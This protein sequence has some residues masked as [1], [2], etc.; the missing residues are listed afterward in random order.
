LKF[1]ILGVDKNY[2]LAFFEEFQKKYNCISF[3]YSWN[4]INESS[5]LS[6]LPR[7]D[8][9]KLYKTETISEAFQLKKISVLDTDFLK[10][11][12]E[13]K[14]VFLNTIDRCAAAPISISKIN[15]LY[16][17]LLQFY[18]SFFEENQMLTHVF[19]P[20]TPHFAPD[21]ILFYVSKYFNKKTIILTRTD[22]DNKY[23]L[24][25]DWRLPV[26]Y[27]DISNKNY[28]NNYNKNASSIFIEHS[29]K[30]NEQS[31]L[32]NL[33]KVNFLDKLKKYYFIFNHTRY[34]YINQSLFSSIYL[35]NDIKFIDLLRIIYNRIKLNK[36]L[37][38]LYISISEN[39]I[40]S[41]KYIY[42]PLHFQP[43]RSTQPEG[44][45]F[46]NQLLA[47]RLLHTNL[48][49]DYMIY[50]KEHPRQFD[51]S[52][53]DL[54]KVHSRI[55]DFYTKI[56][57]L[58]RVKLINIDYNSTELI[59]NASIVATITGSS[60]WQALKT[61]KPIFIFGYPWYSSCFGAFVIKNSN[62][63]V[64]SFKEIKKLNNYIISNEVENFI[65]RIYPYLIDGYTGIKGVNGE[66]PNL[67]LLA[68]SFSKKL[69]SYAIQIK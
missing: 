7:I 44:S 31:L 23:I 57:K 47:I 64:N 19:F 13:C 51:N 37:F 38:N 39:P 9:S 18:K 25:I 29:K 63:I 1:L 41:I 60:G 48:P 11:M 12:L 46:E 50:V 17:E 59:N 24:N 30:L 45:F 22:F 32:Y 55:P 61:G 3:I 5:S 67:D 10:E 62:D 14:T 15:T 21:I 68:E 20:A 36:T 42:F 28:L 27:E 56:K 69:H 26:K 66:E 2:M 6:S 16:Y 54:R 35:N 43:E 65:N 53:P 40:L 49:E 52:T 58:S 33:E 34:I 8:A 4:N